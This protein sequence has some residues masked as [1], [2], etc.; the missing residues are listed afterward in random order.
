MISWDNALTISQK[1]AQDS[2]ADAQTFLN[3]MMNIGYKEVLVELGRQVT[4]LQ[5]TTD[6]VASQRNYQAPPDCNWVKTMVLIDGNT[7]TP[8]LPI[9]SDLQWEVLRSNPQTGKPTNFHFRPRFGIGGGIIELNPIPSSSNYD[10]ELTYEANER[11]LS[12]VEYTT[13]T[14]AVTNNSATVTGSGT[15]FAAD[16]VGRYLII[17]SDGA[18]RLAYRIKQV[19]STTSITLENVYHGTTASGLSYK[20]FEAFAL[21]E[22]IHMLPIYYAEWHWWDT[23]GN[24]QKAGRFEKLYSRGLERGKRVHALTSRDNI[25]ANGWSNYVMPFEEGLPAHFPEEVT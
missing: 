13:G 5:A 2:S 9:D 1:L 7:R 23:R 12:K 14:I 17:T 8:I 15:T 10:I 22:D 20:I 3:M 6:C 19:G 4:E 21:P 25:V 24:A 18:Q 11:D 16:M